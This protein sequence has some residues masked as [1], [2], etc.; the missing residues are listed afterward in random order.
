MKQDDTGDPGRRWEP[1]DGEQRSRGRAQIKIRER[2]QK[3]RPS[4][5]ALFFQG[6]RLPVSPPALRITFRKQ[7]IRY[8]RACRNTVD[9]LLDFRSSCNSCP[10]HLQRARSSRLDNL[11]THSVANEL[12]DGMNLELSH[13]IRAMRFRRLHTDAQS[14]CDFLARLAFGK[15]LNDFAF[16]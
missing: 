5:R 10:G 9:L 12:A 3:N 4:P 8:R 13:D 1:R 2:K 15:K 7:S 16:A 14:G 11:V 6:T